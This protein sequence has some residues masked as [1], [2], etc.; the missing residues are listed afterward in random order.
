MQAR[1]GSYYLEFLGRQTQPLQGSQQ[2]QAVVEVKAE[3]DNIRT[4]WQ[5]AVAHQKAGEIGQATESLGMFYDTQGWFHEAETIFGQAVASLAGQEEVKEARERNIA[6]GQVLSQQGYFLFR[7]GLLG[8]S[9][10][11]LQHSLALLRRFE[12]RAEMA[13][14]LF[15]LGGVTWLMGEYAEA[16]SLLQ[17]ALVI[18]RE[19]QIVGQ[20]LA[21]CLGTLGL[22][23]Q[24]QG[25]YGEA[26]R[27]MQQAG[28]VEREMGNQ[29]IIAIGLS[30]IGAL[31][32]AMG[33]PRAAQ[34]LLQESLVLNRE[35]GDPSSIALALNHLGALA[36]L[37]GTIEWAEARRLHQQS[38]A[39]SQELDDLYGTAVSLN[40]LS[41]ASLALG[42][43]REARRY[44][45]TALRTAMATQSPPL[46]LDTLV[47]WVALLT[48]QSADQVGAASTEPELS[49][50][51][52][53]EPVLT[54]V[55]GRAL[56]L[57]ALALNHPASTQ[58]TKDKAGRLF[59]ELAASLP[60]HQVAAASARGQARNL[61]EVVAEIL[62][63]SSP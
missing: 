50:V 28:V 19:R 26:K 23:A 6:L 58:E 49:P 7:L 29:R 47:G 16:R 4:A 13:D 62:Q 14:T 36:A 61:V 54:E 32:L 21:L 41:Q 1:H 39:I 60:P 48:R 42:E 34:K 15:N 24:T 2:K 43:H 35:V 46:I 12:A 59:N 3:I 25:D 5:W 11:L 51:E 20:G 33:E 53:Q 10:E 18:Y 37:G 55:E 40:Y 27:R 57:L 38:L 44:S 30:L 22:V 45:L 17:E 56:E 63:S 31:A 9:R 52:V 8:Q